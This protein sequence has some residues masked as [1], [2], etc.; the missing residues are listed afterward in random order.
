MYQI[1]VTFLP[2]IQNIANNRGLLTL[3]VDR[4]E[5]ETFKEALLSY[6]FLLLSRPA[7]MRQ[8]P[9]DQV[10]PSHLGKYHTHLFT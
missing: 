6:A 3:L 10:L 7:M 1:K 5:D 2:F 8:K 4:A 9:V